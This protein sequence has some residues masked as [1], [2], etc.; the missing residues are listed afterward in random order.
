MALDEGQ[1]QL[2][3]LVDELFEAAVFLSP[4]SGLGHQIHR[5]VGGMGFAFELP[6][7]VMARV[8]ETAGA[9]AAG[10]AAGAPEGDQAGGQDRTFGLEL[11]LPGLEGAADEGGVFGYFHACQGTFSGPAV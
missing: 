6:G 10:V 11:F 9:A 3:D 1:G 7:E 5:D 8:L 4:L 2:G